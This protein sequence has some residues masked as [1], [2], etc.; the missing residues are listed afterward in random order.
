MQLLGPGLI[1]KGDTRNCSGK[2]VYEEFL[3]RETNQK[4]CQIKRGVLG[5]NPAFG[6][7]GTHLSVRLYIWNKHFP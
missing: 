2:H 7:L 5:L 3:K 4:Y 1:E 6:Y